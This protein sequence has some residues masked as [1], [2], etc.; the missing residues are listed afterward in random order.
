MYSRKKNNRF[1]F[2]YWGNK[3]KIN[4]F[5]KEISRKKSLKI[6]INPT[7]KKETEDENELLTNFNGFL[8]A[9]ISGNKSLCHECEVKSSLDVNMSLVLRP[10]GEQIF[11]RDKE[12][13]IFGTESEIYV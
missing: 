6:S 4:S 1:G 5:K 12:S 2:Q 11:A 9:K 7:E 13:L 8:Q 10:D 3:I